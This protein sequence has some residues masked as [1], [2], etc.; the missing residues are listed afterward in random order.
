MEAIS[1]AGTSL[2]ILGTDGILLAAEKR[3][4]SKLLDPRQAMEKIFPISK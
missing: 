1:H 3:V 4:V 2:G